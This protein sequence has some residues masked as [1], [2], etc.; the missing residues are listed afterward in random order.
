MPFPKI[1]V[2]F[3]LIAVSLGSALY[4]TP[5]D[6]S[7]ATIADINAAIDAGA[8]SSEKLVTLYLARLDAYDQKGPKINS[9][10]TL[11]H[12]VLEEAKTL[13]AERKSKGRR[14][15]LHGIP[16]MIKDLI[17]VAGLPTTAGFKPFGAPVPP[18]DAGV[19]ER[20][21]KAGAIV[22]AKVATVNWF[23]K[24]FDDTHPIGRTMNPYNFD[25]TPGMSSNGVGASMAAYFGTVGIGTDT[26]GSVQIPS[27]Y[28]SLV[29]MVATQG[30]VTRTG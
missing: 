26:G 1:I 8:L 2:L 20:L 14:S 3:G 23:G 4:G 10:I 7:T 27:S 13:D 25:Y 11:N 30:M 29:G 28:C 18:R 5:F 21:H 22:L 12:K 6:L 24:G 16:V 19:V 9:V 15:P 17:D